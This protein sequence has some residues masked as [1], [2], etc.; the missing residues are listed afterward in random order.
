[1]LKGKPSLQRQSKYQNQTR[2]DIQVWE[3][4]DMWNLKW[5]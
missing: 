1:M 4:L 5:L 2:I 3:L